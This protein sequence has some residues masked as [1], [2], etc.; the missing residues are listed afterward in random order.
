MPRTRHSPHIFALFPSLQE[1]IL[2]GL[3][4]TKFRLNILSIYYLHLFVFPQPGHL[5]AVCSRQLPLSNSQGKAHILYFI[6]FSFIDFYIRSS[7][8]FSLCMQYDYESIIRT[9]L[10]SCI[11]WLFQSSYSATGRTSDGVWGASSVAQYSVICHSQPGRER[12]TLNQHQHTE[13]T[14]I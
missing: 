2:S 3:C 14:S 8:Y 11:W 9:Y 10:V 13:L 12:T 1:A 6:D 5:R 7:W 4:F